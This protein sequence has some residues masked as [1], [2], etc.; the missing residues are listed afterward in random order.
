MIVKSINIR[1][2]GY[3]GYGAK[4]KAT[5]PF[6]AQVE[7]ESPFG[8]IKLNLDADRTQQIVSVIA[9]LIA[10]AGQETARALTAEVING[11]AL[12]PAE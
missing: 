11:D 1:R 5:D 3:Y 7:V 6:L 4:P 8:E 12:L 9:D 2:P 10:E